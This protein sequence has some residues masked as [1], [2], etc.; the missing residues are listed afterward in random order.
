MLLQG[1]R[2]GGSGV[3]LKSIEHRKIKINETHQ[4]LRQFTQI[5]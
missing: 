4:A 5:G 3:S 1:M 2:T